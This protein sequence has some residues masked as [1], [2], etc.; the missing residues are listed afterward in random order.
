MPHQ[1]KEVRFCRTIL[2]ASIYNFERFLLY[3]YILIDAK[4][5]EEEVTALIECKNT[6]PFLEKAYIYVL[7]LSVFLM[8]QRECQ[9]Y[10]SHVSYHDVTLIKNTI[11]MIILHHYV[12]LQTVSKWWFECNQKNWFAF[13]FQRFIFEK[14]KLIWFWGNEVQNGW[15]NLMWTKSHTE[16]WTIGSKNFEKRF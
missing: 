2:R 4:V 1:C 12:L 3:L 14:E 6:D 7:F 10:S 16:D 9:T 8:R 15:E 11:V 13:V 5:T